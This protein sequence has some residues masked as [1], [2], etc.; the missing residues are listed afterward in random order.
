[1]QAKRY[2]LLLALVKAMDDQGSWCGE[3]HLQKASYFLQDAANVPLELDFTLYKHGPYSFELHEVL[4]DMRARLLID[5]KPQPAPYGPS[6]KQGPS[7]SI[8]EKSFPRTLASYAP[9][10]DF[11]AAK[12]SRHGAVDLER[13]ATAL[14][15]L[16]NYHDDED[17]VQVIRRL[18]PHISTEQAAEAL[19]EV[20]SILQ[21]IALRYA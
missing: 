9:Q 5:V 16:R 10:I 15:V 21:E 8:L 6:L 1:M 2:A 17:K 4:G 20:E 14:Y 7:A 11:V 3:T 12:L 19:T 18:K 13:L